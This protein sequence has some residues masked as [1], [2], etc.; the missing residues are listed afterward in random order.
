[1]QID[2]WRPRKP[3]SVTCWP[4]TEQLF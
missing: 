3:Q 4:F 1:M 2:I